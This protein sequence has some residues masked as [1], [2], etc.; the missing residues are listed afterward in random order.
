MFK[1]VH[2]LVYIYCSVMQIIALLLHTYHEKPG[3][4][5]RLSKGAQLTWGGGN[6]EWGGNGEGMGRGRSV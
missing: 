1:Y 3:S 6:L 4:Q 5:C 2:Y